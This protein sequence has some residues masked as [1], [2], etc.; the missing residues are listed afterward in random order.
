MRTSDL[1]RRR[2]T[3]IPLANTRTVSSLKNVEMNVVAVVAVGARSKHCGK[4]MT[5]RIPQC[6]TE[7]LRN[8]FIGKLYATISS[9]DQGTDIDSVALAMFAKFG[10]Q[11]IV[12]A[13]AFVRTI[14]LDTAW[15]S[16]QS[17]DLG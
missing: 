11:H 5:G 7:R 16:A 15:C 3:H 4:A 17:G 12:T 13:A 6:L 2:L 14:G 8:G 9:E 10:I 1:G